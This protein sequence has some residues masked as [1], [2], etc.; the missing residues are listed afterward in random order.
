MPPPI[1]HFFD[2]GYTS[3]KALLM[4]A[5]AL[6]YLLWACI[7][8]RKANERDRKNFE[9]LKQQNLSHNE[10]DLKISQLYKKK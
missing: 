1:F 5:I 3:P 9:K 4:F 10:N 6:S 8:T 7:I 2:E